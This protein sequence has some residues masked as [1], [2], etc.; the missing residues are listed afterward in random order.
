MAQGDPI[1]INSQAEL[2]ELFKSTTYVAIDFY[3]DWCGPC[4]V[5]AVPLAELSR[6]YSLPGLFAVA[7]VNCDVARDVA[8]QYNIT[9]MPTF[10]FFK[11]GRK[12]AVNGNPHILGAN[13][14]TL[15]EAITKLGDLAAKK[16]GASSVSIGCSC[17]CH[18]FSTIRTRIWIS[19]SAG[20]DMVRKHRHGV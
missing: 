15:K 18:G 13:L 9:A 16:A 2:D 10:M 12:V 19:M 20:R 4:K 7:K 17:R 11:D 6:T 3:A 5:I 14:P 1:P 8:A